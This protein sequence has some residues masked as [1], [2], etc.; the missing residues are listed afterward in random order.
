MTIPS[1]SNK[2]KPPSRPSSPAPAARRQTNFDSRLGSF[3]SD[4]AIF[5]D[6]AAL[7]GS[8]T[9]GRPVT[10]PFA[11]PSASP[12]LLRTGDGS[13]QYL[14]QDTSS[15]SLVKSEVSN[16]FGGRDSDER[17]PLSTGTSTTSSS[18]RVK[19]RLNQGTKSPLGLTLSDVY[20]LV[21]GVCLGAFFM[22]TLTQFHFS[23]AELSRLSDGYK[24]MIMRVIQ[25]DV[26]DPS[27]PEVK[28]RQHVA[29]ELAERTEEIQKKII[30]PVPRAPAKP[31]PKGSALPNRMYVGVL[32]A[33]HFIPTRVTAVHNAWGKY[34]DPHIQVSPQVLC[35]C[36]KIHDCTFT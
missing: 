27:E 22:S 36:L 35:L 14:G 2:R 25:G 6:A 3:R 17:T 4:P 18:S 26:A 9:I 29:P 34:L 10:V 1:D 32:S 15:A 33:K 16:H 31:V 13:S 30:P 20:L 23:D 5:G 19:R 7:V 12:S 28:A 21:F 8:K 24:L 11:S